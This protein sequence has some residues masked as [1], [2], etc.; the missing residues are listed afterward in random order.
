MIPAVPDDGKVWLS[1]T[2]IG[3]AFAVRRD[4]F[5]RLGGFQELLFHWA[6]EGEYTLRLMG[7][8]YVC[9]IGAR[10]MIRH[11]PGGTGKYPRQVTRYIY[12][13]G[14]FVLW[15]DAPTL[16]MPLLIAGRI[17]QYLVFDGLL[18]PKNLPA[19]LEGF[20]MAIKAMLSTWRIRTPLSMHA[21]RMWL[22]IRRER[23]IEFSRIVH[24]LPP[25]R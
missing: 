1:N 16:L 11:Y 9:A 6:E 12:R 7:A 19:V 21:Y 3:T 23:P 15:L 8:G 18:R 14:I 2:F 13:N 17:A 4:V 5:L 22:R 25:M 10:G 20:C 24:E